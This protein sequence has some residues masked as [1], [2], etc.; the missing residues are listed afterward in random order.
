MDRGWH[1]LARYQRIAGTGDAI[2]LWVYLRVLLAQFKFKHSKTND[3]FCFHCSDRLFLVRNT[4]KLR[5]S[6]ITWELGPIP[7]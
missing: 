5:M 3:C 4:Q 2:R 6:G 1:L 7:R